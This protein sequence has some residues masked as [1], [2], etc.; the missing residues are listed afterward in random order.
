MAD[1]RRLFEASGSVGKMMTFAVRLDTFAA[2]Q[3]TK[4]FYIGTNDVDVLTDIRRHA[5]ANFT[6]LPIGGEYMHHDAFDV[7]KRYGKDLFVII[8]RFGTDRLPLFF[9]WKTRADAWFERLGFMPKHL[10]DR[11]L[12]W[13]S[14]RLPEHLPARLMQYRDR[15]EHHLMLKV[16]AAGVEEAR[17]FLAKRFE[18]GGGAYFECDKKKGARSF[19]IA[20]RR[21]ARR[22]AIARCIIARLKISSRSTSRYAATIATG[23]NGCLSISRRRSS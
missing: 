20:S 7:A 22:C 5:L 3:G 8:D 12:Q 1:P 21:R 14:E 11:L 4:V 17:A 10:P 6:H 13:F 2:E 18:Q 16:K 23:S 15:F 19:C 9:N